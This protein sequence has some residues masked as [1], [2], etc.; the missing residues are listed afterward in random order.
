MPLW[1]TRIFR[2]YTVGNL[3]QHQFPYSIL[4]YHY[5][6]SDFGEVYQK[7]EADI[8]SFV[9]LPAGSDCKVIGGPS[10]SLDSPVHTRAGDVHTAYEMLLLKASIFASITY[11]CYTKQGSDFLPFSKGRNKN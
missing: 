9:T 6:N 7:Y 5:E 4:V 8:I 11:L 10:S 1:F 2:W 3:V